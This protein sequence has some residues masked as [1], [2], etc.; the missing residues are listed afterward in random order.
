[1]S[2][3]KCAACEMFDILYPNPKAHVLAG[4]WDKIKSRHSKPAEPPHQP[5]G[6]AKADDIEVV[7]DP[8]EIAKVMGT[9]AFRSTIETIEKAKAT[10]PAKA[11][12]DGLEQR[13]L[14]FCAADEIGYQP[15]FSHRLRTAR[16][17]RQV[18]DEAVAAKDREIADLNRQIVILVTRCNTAEAREKSLK[19]L[20]DKIMDAI[21]QEGTN[22]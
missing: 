11:E 15:I 10:E 5:E 14:E 8:K 22:Q 21:R 2:D 9:P 13:F 4:Q 16:F 1:M 18:R 19:E 3:H 7:E 17:A 12:D 6:T 20:G